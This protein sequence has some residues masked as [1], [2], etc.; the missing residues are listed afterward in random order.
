VA[1][2]AKAPLFIVAKHVTAAVTA[3]H[4]M[5][6][7]RAKVQ[8]LKRNVAIAGLTNAESELHNDEL[9]I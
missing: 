5:S 6:A 8:A 3:V 7:T 2:L 9:A 1:C 4:P